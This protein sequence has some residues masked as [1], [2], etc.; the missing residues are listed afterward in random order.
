MKFKEDLEAK[1]LR[2]HVAFLPNCGFPITFCAYCFPVLDIPPLPPLLSGEGENYHLLTPVHIPVKRPD[3][4]WD[5]GRERENEW[6]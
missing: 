6:V 4:S 3:G 1:R 2:R 5:E